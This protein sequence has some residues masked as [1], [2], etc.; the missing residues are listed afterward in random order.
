MG[1]STE[2]IRDIQSQKV[3]IIFGWALD[4]KITKDAGTVEFAVRFYSIEK[5]DTGADIIQYSLSTLPAKIH[6]SKGMNMDILSNDIDIFT[7]EE[8]QFIFDRIK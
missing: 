7:K 5:D 1:I 3:K 4:Q 8:Q 6:I 2:L